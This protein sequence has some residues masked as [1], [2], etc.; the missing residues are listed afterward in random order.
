M[1]NFT[2]SLYFRGHLCIS[3]E[4]LGMNLY[5][6]IKAYEFK[7]FSLRLIR[8]FCKQMLAS[9]TLLKTQHVIHCDPKIFCLLTHCILRSRSSTSGLVVS[10]TR[11]CTL[12]SSHGSTGHPRLY[13]A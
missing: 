7:G 8:R 12:T 2:Q 4:L 9:L 10:R 1:I 6:F 13:L 5:E 3:T 11:R